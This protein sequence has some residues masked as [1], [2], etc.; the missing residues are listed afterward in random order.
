[1]NVYLCKAEKIKW[2][3]AEDESAA[4]EKFLS[5]LDD[6]ES[7]VKIDLRGKAPSNF[8]LR[9]AISM[10]ESCMLDQCI[11]QGIV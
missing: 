9:A 11:T 4:K 5:M 10:G 3:T 7:N 2:I 1:M 8:E 6:L